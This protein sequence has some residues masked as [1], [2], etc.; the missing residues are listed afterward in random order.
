MQA[1]LPEPFSL[2]E[3]PIV[4]PVRQ[5][6]VEELG[7]L[8]T[9]FVRLGGRED[10]VRRSLRLADIDRDVTGEPEL[11]ACHVDES[12]IAAV[13]SPEC[14]TQVCIGSL[15]RRIQ[16]QHT[17]DVEAQERT[18]VERKERHESPG[19]HLQAHRGARAHKLEASEQRQLCASRRRSQPQ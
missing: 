10:P 6:I 3:Y 14:R 8:E 11:L 17:G 18:V 1:H 13:Q 19:A 12:R 7:R 4:V 2:E 15:F 9:L 5:Q 16:P